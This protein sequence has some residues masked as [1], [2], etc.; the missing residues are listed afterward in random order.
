MQAGALRQTV[1]EDWIVPFVVVT[2]ALF[3]SWSAVVLAVDP[4]QRAAG[5]TFDGG[6]SLLFLPHG[7]RVLAAWVFGWRSVLFLCPGTLIVHCIVVSDH[8]FMLVDFAALLIGATC[9]VIAFAGL[10]RVGLDFRFR[11]DYQPRWRDIMLAGAIASVIN[12]FFT[13]VVLGHPVGN[14]AGYLVGD[15]AGLFVA[16]FL[17]MLAFRWLRTGRTRA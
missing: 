13:N 14:M 1:V 2:L 11:A 17:L 4:I 3:I 16:L 12:S 6:A 9:G 5:L 7:V 15:I 10:A 8:A